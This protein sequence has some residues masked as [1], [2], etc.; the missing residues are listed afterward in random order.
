[1]SLGVQLGK[2]LVWIDPEVVT[3]TEP[4]NK[5][6]STILPIHD[7]YKDYWLHLPVI[8]RDELDNLDSSMQAVDQGPVSV[9]SDSVIP[10]QPKV[11]KHDTSIALMDN[12]NGYEDHSEVGNDEEVKQI[13]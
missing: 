11:E 1:M 3:K 8:L 5:W 12:E 7:T 4:T 6:A 13:L 9:T 10:L 2:Y